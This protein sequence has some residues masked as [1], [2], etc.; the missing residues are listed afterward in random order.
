MIYEEK[1]VSSE[2][3]FDGRIVKLRVDKVEMPDGRIATREVVGHPGGV[4]IVAVTENDEIVLV[5]QY[6][7]PIEDAIYEIPAGKLDEGEHH[8]TCGIRELE[9]ETGY[10]AGKFEYLGFIY[11]SPG[12]TDEVTYVY[13]AEDLHEGE[14]HPDEGEFLEIEKI[15]AQKVFEMVMSGEINDAK[16]VFGILKYWA[17]RTDRK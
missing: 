15:P 7:Y 4:G 11:P 5:R 6:R 16:S 13:L 14:S 1:S 2:K 17:M 10:S 8:R 9:E 3:I 12:F